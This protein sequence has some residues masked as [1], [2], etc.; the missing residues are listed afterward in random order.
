MQRLSITDVAF[1]GFRLVREHPKAV[2]VWG[3][4]SLI[5]SFVS[6]ALLILLAGPKMQVLDAMDPADP[7]D[8]KAYIL[9]TLAVMPSMLLAS[10]IGLVVSAIVLTGVYRRILRPAQAGGPVVRLG[11]EEVRQGVVLFLYFLAV[12]VAYFGSLI[13]AAALITIV[14]VITGSQPVI[15][16]LLVLLAIGAVIGCTIW[17]VVR[18]SFSGAITFVSGRIDMTTSLK[19][20]RGAFWPLFWAY[21]L[22]GVLFVIVYLAVVVLGVAVAVIIGGLGSARQVLKPDLTSLA[23]FFTPAGVIQ[24]LMSG[25][26]SILASLVLFA[27]APTAYVELKG[28]APSPFD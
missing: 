23:A 15:V 1:S 28:E 2:A 7:A 18:L 25:A 21:L 8:V 5:S 13:V 4:L 14:G 24:M 11:V 6:T 20:T 17:T 22:A 9:Q 26:L 3:V 27:P 19:L 16:A 10:L 12:A